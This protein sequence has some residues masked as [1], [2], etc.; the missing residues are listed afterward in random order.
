MLRTKNYLLFGSQHNVSILKFFCIELYF[1]VHSHSNSSLHSESISRQL[2]SNESNS[3][4]LTSNDKKLTP[5][6]TQNSSPPL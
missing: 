2:F 3:D 1:F 5:K 4:Q 6:S